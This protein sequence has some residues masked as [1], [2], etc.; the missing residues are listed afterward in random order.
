MDDIDLRL[1]ALE[2]AAQSRPDD[3]LA[4]AER[5]LAWLTQAPG[6]ASAPKGRKR[7]GN[8]REA[9]MRA[10]ELMNGGMSRSAAARA[11]GYSSATAIVNAAARYDIQLPPPNMNDPRVAN[12]VAMAKNLSAARAAKRLA[13]RTTTA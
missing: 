10:I 6:P 2:I 4:E 8:A 11:L 1:R 13:A 9:V 3:V 7:Y 12:A 5:V